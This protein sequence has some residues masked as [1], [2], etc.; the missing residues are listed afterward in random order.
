MIHIG[1]TGG[2]ASGKSTVAR[3]F[4]YHNVPVFDADATVHELYERADIIAL[5]GNHFPSAIKDYAICRQSLGQ[6]L[7]ASPSS[8]VK[9]NALIHPL[10]RQEEQNFK[11]THIALGTDTI[12]TDIPL[13]VES[14]ACSRYD[15]R[16]MTQAPLWLRKKRAFTRSAQMTDEKWQLILSK[17]V[18]DAE[19]RKHMD[20]VIH[21]GLNKNYTMQQ[22]KH[23]L[24][25]L[26]R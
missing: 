9:L 26:G 25:L 14:N 8:I 22:I 24:K 3:L 1:L 6:L 11:K 7:Q 4:R 17:Q 12:L 2:I 5:V 23:W 18:T 10:V 21:T 15:V 13:M 19:R 20:G 16:L